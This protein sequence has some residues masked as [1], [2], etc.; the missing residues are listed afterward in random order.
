MPPRLPIPWGGLVCVP[1][2]ATWTARCLA[3]G[4]CLLACAPDRDGQGAHLWGMKLLMGLLA[5]ALAL[6]VLALAIEGLR[7]LFMVAVIVLLSVSLWMAY[8]HARVRL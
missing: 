3:S 7:W 4:K 2:N 5:L 1:V 6:A 8:D